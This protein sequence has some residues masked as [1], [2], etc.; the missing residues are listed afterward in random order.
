MIWLQH[1]DGAVNVVYT[2]MN[3]G[4][5]SGEGLSSDYLKTIT[6]SDVKPV[7]GDW[8]NASLLNQVNVHPVFNDGI[9]IP[10]EFIELIKNSENKGVILVEGS[11]PTVKP[12]KLIIKD[13]NNNKILEASLP[14]NIYQVTDL[15]RQVS[16]RGDIAEGSRSEISKIWG[17]A[18]TGMLPQVADL[19]AELVTQKT[20]IAARMPEI[21]L[22][23]NVIFLHGSLIDAIAASEFQAE[24]FKRL[25]HSGSNAL[26]TGVHWYGD[27]GFVAG[28]NYWDN[29]EN[30][31]YTADDLAALVNEIDG[32]KNIIAHSLANMMAGSAIQDFG[33]GF[34]KYFM[35]NPAV[36]LE[37]Y[38]ANIAHPQQMR[39][40]DWDEYYFGAD[41]NSADVTYAD[42]NGR[43]LW[44]VEWYRFFDGTNDAR[45]NLTWR[46]RFAKVAA[47]TNVIQYYSSGDEVLQP[48]EE[49]DPNDLGPVF[50]GGR[51]AWNIQEKGKGTTELVALLG[52][53]AAAGWGFNET[54]ETDPT[55]NTETC[56]SNGVLTYTQAESFFNKTKEE[57]ILT[58]Y[59][60]P[61]SNTGLNDANTN[62]SNSLTAVNKNYPR[63]LAYELPALSFAA[64][65]TKV[66]A[67][68]ITRAFD[69]NTQMTETGIWPATRLE[70]LGSIQW[71]HSDF[72]NIA[73]RY[74]YKLFDDMT[75]R[76]AL[77]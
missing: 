51:N 76:G 20:Q 65:G 34:N 35:L 68:P 31:F 38:Q 7:F 72:K 48:G 10:K 74:T 53:G 37:A 50:S 9:E 39:N 46:N 64:G 15:Y 52:G 30:A 6:M 60:D 21:N 27:E 45:K 56:N 47:N 16:L 1:D 62:E 23:K 26:F 61:F 44:S 17:E 41:Y 58:P 70:Q 19:L 66:A 4:I 5:V 77:K 8:Q 73:Y 54:C 59:F 14:I 67:F 18:P 63:T 11:A 24:T 42:Q 57:L 32:T 69:M 28:V 22:T 25:Y 2:A 40:T 13:E 75:A 36:A 12:L 49:G 33:M 71:L 3:R 43:K 29:V 55:D